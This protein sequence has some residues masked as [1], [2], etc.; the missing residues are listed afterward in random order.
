M[1]SQTQWT[2][3]PV[4]YFFFARVLT[5]GLA[6]AVLLYARNGSKLALLIVIY[7]TVFY[8]DRILIGGRRQE[9]VE[10]AVIFLMAF[11]FQRGWCVPRSLML[12]GMVAVAL[13]INSVGEYRSLTMHASGPQWQAIADIDFVGNLSNISEHGGEEVKNAVYTIAAVS[14]TMQL[15]LG[16]YHWNSLIFAYVPAQLV[17]AE[18]KQAYYISLSQPVW[19]EF[20]YTPQ[21]GT[22]LTGLSDAF[23]SFWY[24]GCLKFFLIAYVMQ[25]LWLAARRGNM[26]AQLLYSLLPVHAMQA[27]THSTQNFVNPWVHL[28][29]F[30]LP[31]LLLARGGSKSRSATESAPLTPIK[32]A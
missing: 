10:F 7:G 21:T 4:A 17:G 5:Y 3:L 31:A 30:L 12:V 19:E 2:G 22:T 13:F 11:C 23:Q 29:I 26:T 9:L 6:L 14:R 18:I 27:I 8:L 28:A 15:D 24:F 1:V 20:L 32:Q 16:L 25:K